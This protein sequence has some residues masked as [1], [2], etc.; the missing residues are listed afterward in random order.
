LKLRWPFSDVWDEV[1]T[2]NKQLGQHGEFKLLLE[3]I[4]TRK[5]PYLALPRL[6]R[7]WRAVTPSP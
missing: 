7:F 6:V 2:R 5:D 3:Y 1:R 4:S